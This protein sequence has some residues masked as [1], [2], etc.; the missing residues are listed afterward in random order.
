MSPALL[1]MSLEQELL[2]LLLVILPAALVLTYV[3]A[4]FH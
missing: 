1:A 3:L 4:F 2:L